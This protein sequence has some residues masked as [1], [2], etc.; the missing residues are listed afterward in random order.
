[1]KSWRDGC[2]CQRPP[3][4][5]AQRRRQS[6]EALCAIAEPFPEI[7]SISFP[8]SLFELASTPLVQQ[9]QVGVPFLQTTA[10]K[11][12]RWRT[13]RAVRFVRGAVSILEGQA[14]RCRPE[15]GAEFLRNE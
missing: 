3:H 11:R 2:F 6:A 1:M 8:E 14:Q 10:R 13:F 7:V 5:P 12:T 15:V 9:A 4:V